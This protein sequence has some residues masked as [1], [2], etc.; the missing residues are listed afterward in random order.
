MDC[1]RMHALGALFLLVAN[2]HADKSA[3]VVHGSWDLYSSSTLLQSGYSDE[4]GCVNG[5]L[6]RA[7]T[8]STYNC[9]T[10]TDVT[11][12]VSGTV[13][14]PAPASGSYSTSFNNTECPLSEGGRWTKTPNP[15]TYVRSANGTAYGS[16]GVTNSYDDS[17][18]Y[19]RGL[20]TDY[21][22][23]AT[24]QKNSG[25]DGGCEV[26]LLL[27]VT[28]DSNNAR[29]VEMDFW[30]NGTVQPVRWNGPFGN[31]TVY[32]SGS[33]CAFTWTPSTPLK[34]GDKI[35]AQA[36]GN[37]FKAWINGVQKACVVDSSMG[38][39]APGIGFFIRPG[40]ATNAMTLADVTVTSP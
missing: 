24:V 39:G 4:Q 9:R 38:T 22:I 16:N 10:R 19:L 15:W 7:T 35:K 36:S 2:A 30:E 17:Y 1:H 14:A 23:E 21:T 37:T 11:I 12:T 3:S 31:F 34:T 29:L 40:I 27:R 26:E 32:G 25:C 8:T 13:S 20:G 28:D 18:A 6:S 33:S 5:A